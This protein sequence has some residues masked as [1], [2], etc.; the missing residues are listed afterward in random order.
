VK[1]WRLAGMVMLLAGCGGESA[2]TLLDDNPGY[3]GKPDK[4]AMAGAE[5]ETVLRQR[6]LKIQTDR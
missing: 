2:D 1:A 3:A 4:H 6:L 5:R